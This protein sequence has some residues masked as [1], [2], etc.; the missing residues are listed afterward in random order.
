MS[1]YNSSNN[2]G[3]AV[4]VLVISV[5]MTISFCVFCSGEGIVTIGILK[6]FASFFI[7]GMG[8]EYATM[9]SA[10]VSFVA[11]LIWIAAGINKINTHRAR[12]A[13]MRAGNR[14]A[15]SP[16]AVNSAQAVVQNTEGSRR[17]Q[18]PR[19]QQQRRRGGSRYTS[20]A[21]TEAHLVLVDDQINP[22][23]II[24]A[25]T[26]PPVETMP[27]ITF[28]GDLDMVAPSS[29]LR[30]FEID[31]N[32]EEDNLERGMEKQVEKFQDTN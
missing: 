16:D 19:T 12:L 2:D 13:A 28:G 3:T 4:L 24:Y 32:Q 9:T 26:V 23:N 8:S 31:D 30:S 6:V 18:V 15:I 1:N 14:R 25:R 5:V 17:D 10:F 27:G 22:S 11:G 7:L 20:V 29:N 21:R